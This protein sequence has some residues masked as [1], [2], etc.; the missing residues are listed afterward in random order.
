MAA[1]KNDLR[2]WTPTQPML[3]CGGH[4]DPNVA[5]ANAQLAQAYFQAHGTTV[6]VLDV[7]S[8]ITANDPYANAKNAFLA[9]ENNI[10]AAGGDPATS[11]NYHGTTAFA[12]CNV[13]A[14]FL[15]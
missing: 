4:G 14:R 11:D 7:D 15:Q 2:T 6:A 3:M 12:G 9:A 13:A 10:I 1:V 5:F 8:P